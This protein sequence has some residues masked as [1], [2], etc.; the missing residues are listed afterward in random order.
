MKRQG[1]PLII[2]SIIALLVLIFSVDLLSFG[3]DGIQYVQI[4]QQWASGNWDAALN[5]YWGPLVSW[6]MIPLLK[7]GVD[8]FL[9]FKIE[10]FITAIFFF[11]LCLRWLKRLG[12]SNFMYWLCLPVIAILPLQWM[13]HETPDLLYST[14]VLVWLELALGL[15]DKAKY[16]YIAGL[17]GALLYLTKAFGFPFFASNLLVVL[18]LLGWYYKSASSS[19][20]L[21]KE[22]SIALGIFLGFSLIWILTISVHYEAA[23]IGTSGS[24]NQLMLGPDN[25]PTEII[26][27]SFV[28]PTFAGNLEFPAEGQLSSWQEPYLSLDLADRSIIENSRH[29]ALNLLRNCKALMYNDMLFAFGLLFTLLVLASRFLKLKFERRDW[30][31]VLLFGITVL[32]TVGGYMLIL[33]QD[34][35]LWSVEILLLFILI[36]SIDRINRPKLV[37]GTISFFSLGALFLLQLNLI[38]GTHTTGNWLAPYFDLKT[39]PELFD[40]D[41]MAAVGSARPGEYRK[42]ALVSNYHKV[43]YHGLINQDYTSAEINTQLDMHDIDLV[44][45]LC[46]SGELKALTRWASPNWILVKDEGASGSKRNW[47]YRIWRRSEKP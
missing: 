45:E 16:P 32:N 40:V 21:L 8:P 6:L 26:N 12:I 33:V 5:A 47:A 29:Y 44:F 46:E 28:L 23:I 43:S 36:L 37:K 39:Q 15:K 38:A 18:I 1:I 3:A 34:R 35:Y 19:Y 41:R 30:F 4:A 42:A 31:F 2:F 22:G 11:W 7:L 20:K 24:Y 17:V 10:R 14:L 9:S 13:L 27:S 25:S